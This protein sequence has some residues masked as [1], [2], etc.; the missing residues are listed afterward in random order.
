LAILLPWQDAPE[1]DSRDDGTVHSFLCAEA[2]LQ[3][4]LADHPG[5]PEDRLCYLLLQA[6][7]NGDLVA[8]RLVVR[9]LPH[10]D[11]E[12]AVRPGDRESALLMAHRGSPDHL[13]IALSYLTPPN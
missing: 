2:M 8:A 6:I 5:A 1:Y 3:R 9:Q 7:L 10:P 4:L 13:R 12:T 11:R